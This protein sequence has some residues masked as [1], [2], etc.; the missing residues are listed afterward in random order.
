MPWQEADKISE[1]EEFIN[2]WLTGR[3]TVTSLCDA[4]GISRKTGHK[5]INRFKSAGMNNL[6]DQSRARYHQAHKTP[7]EIVQVL[8]DTK[9]LYPDWGPRKVVSYLKNTQPDISWPVHST[10]SD[11]F[12]QHGLVKPRGPRRYKAPARTEPLAHATAPNRVWSVDFKG[13]FLLGNGKRCYPL[14]VFDNHSRYLLECKAL[15]STQ[16]QPVIDA[17]ETLFQCYGLPE[18]LRSDNGNP[19]ASTRIGGL[20]RF[21]LWLLKCGVKPERTKPGHPQEN[22]RHERFHRSG[23]HM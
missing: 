14:R 16:T 1:R 2:R 11:I 22:G 18:Y 12:S 3:Q 23:G 15:Y 19:F 9:F 17:F 10:V 5:W 8:I 20:S 6:A 7:E 13:D 21:S 4:F